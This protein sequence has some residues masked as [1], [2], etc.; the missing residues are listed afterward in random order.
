MRSLLGSLSSHPSPLGRHRVQLAPSGVI[1]V[2]DPPHGARVCPVACS[3]DSERWAATV[4]A[5]GL[6]LQAAVRE[7]SGRFLPAVYGMA[8]HAP[9]REECVPAERPNSHTMMDKR[10]SCLFLRKIN[11]KQMVSHFVCIFQTCFCDRNIKKTKLL[12]G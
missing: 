9:G 3:T 1:V 5:C 10:A 8:L 12:H 6:A 11:I 2:M 4:S 7:P